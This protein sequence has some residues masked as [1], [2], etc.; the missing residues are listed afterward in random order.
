MSL[1]C[2]TE[3]GSLVAVRKPRGLSASSQPCQ[4]PWGLQGP[5]RR[6]SSIC[7]LSMP[8]ASVPI[9]TG[10]KVFTKKN[11]FCICHQEQWIET[12][13]KSLCYFTTVLAKNWKVWNGWW[14]LGKEYETGWFSVTCL[15]GGQGHTR[16]WTGLVTGHTREQE[17]AWGSLGIARVV[18]WGE[19]SGDW[20]G[21]LGEIA[22]DCYY[23]DIYFHWLWYLER[24]KSQ[25]RRK[26]GFYMNSCI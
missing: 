15:M 3:D 6:E 19:G 24:L 1:P 25:R 5:S 10:S 21:S 14:L 22:T 4:T 16:I 13:G 12:A 2:A 9:E 17:S 26:R 11:D 18:I 8:L 7:H 23:W 20:I